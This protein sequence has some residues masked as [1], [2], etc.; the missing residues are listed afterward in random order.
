MPDLGLDRVICV[1]LWA[2]C[3][4]R[5]VLRMNPYPPTGVRGMSMG[6]G[7]PFGGK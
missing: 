4:G 2:L 1:G 5:R 3:C 7:L 6:M